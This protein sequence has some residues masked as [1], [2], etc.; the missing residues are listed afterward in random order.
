[1]ALT[2]DGK[3]HIVMTQEQRDFAV[4]DNRTQHVRLTFAMRRLEGCLGQAA[5]GREPD[6]IKE[7]SLALDLLLAAMSESQEL[8][9]RDGSLIDEI[10]YTTPRLLKR[11][12]NLR[13]EFD[14]LVAQARSLQEQLAHAGNRS[15]MSFA[16]LRQRVDRLLSAM[17]HHQAKEVD[18]IYEAINVD[19]GIGD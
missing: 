10:K 13:N 12:E 15:N 18:L 14:G 2:S 19:I 16:D 3:D 8:V 4:D 9:C 7:V 17:K 11:I 6:W 5:P 1:M